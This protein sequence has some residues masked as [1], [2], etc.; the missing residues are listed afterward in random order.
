MCHNN[1]TFCQILDINFFFFN[2]ELLVEE[3]SI[4][5]EHYVRGSEEAAFGSKRIG[6][7]ELPKPLIKGIQD[8]VEGTMQHAFVQKWQLTSYL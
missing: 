6:C 2:S 3:I 7:V 4:T 1:F 5:S 8:L